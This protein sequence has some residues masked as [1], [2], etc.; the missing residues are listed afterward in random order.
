MIWELVVDAVLKFGW[1]AA[2]VTAVIL[3][4]SRHWKNKRAPDPHDPK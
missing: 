3:I 2:L 4:V 1:L